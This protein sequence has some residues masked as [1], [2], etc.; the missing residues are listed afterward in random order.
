MNAHYYDSERYGVKIFG[1]AQV[2]KARYQHSPYI[3]FNKRF[4][5]FFMYWEQK[6]VN[7]GK[8]RD[9]FSVVKTTMKYA[10]EIATLAFTDNK[11]GIAL[12]E[13]LD[14]EMEALRDY[15]EWMKMK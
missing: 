4:Q 6:N 1:F 8:A 12:K 13:F 10:E 11:F 5:M 3:E 2:I 7:I 15:H 9:L 14:A